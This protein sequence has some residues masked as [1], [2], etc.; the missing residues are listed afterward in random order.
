MRGVVDDDADNVID[1]LV[2]L[3]DLDENGELDSP[4]AAGTDVAFVHFKELSVELASPR[5]DP[6]GAR[7]PGPLGAGPAYRVRTFKSF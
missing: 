4:L 2:G 7:G 5:D 3:E 6:S 1:G